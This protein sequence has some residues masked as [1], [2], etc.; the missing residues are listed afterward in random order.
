LE[1]VREV[2]EAEYPAFGEREDRGVVGTVGQQSFEAGNE[3]PIHG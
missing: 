2:G 1:L 3:R